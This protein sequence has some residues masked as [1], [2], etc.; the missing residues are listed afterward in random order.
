MTTDQ[1]KG[2]A[3]ELGNAY[4]QRSPGNEEANFY[5]FRQ[6]LYRINGRPRPIVPKTLL[7]LGAGT[8]ANVRALY[9]LFPDLEITALEINEQAVKTLLGGMPKPI[10]IQS[11]VLGWIPARKWD[12]VLTKGLLIHIPPAQLPEVYDTIYQACGRWILL[13]E[14]YSPRLEMIPYRGESDRLWKGPHAEQMLKRYDG[15]R[16]LDYGFVSKL[17]AQPQDDVTWW[18]LERT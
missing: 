2:W 11:S 15:L 8:G 13:A 9:R 16:L 5:L 4:N 6:A 18:I 14:Y 3:G 7:E 10:M 1:E 12:M 17:D